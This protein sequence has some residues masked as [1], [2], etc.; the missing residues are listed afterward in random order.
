MNQQTRAAYFGAPTIRIPLAT[1]VSYSFNFSSWH[2]STGA[3]ASVFFT[4]PKSLYLG[5]IKTT[6]QGHRLLLGLK[7][8]DI[9]FGTDF[10]FILRRRKTVCTDACKHVKGRAIDS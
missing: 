5:P 1:D 8:S 3:D 7:E 10:L 4:T 9:K 2:R 6:V